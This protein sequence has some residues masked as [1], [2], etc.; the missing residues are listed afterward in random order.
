MLM[1]KSPVILMII[2][3]MSLLPVL[4]G[5]HTPAGRSAGEVID[6]STIATKVKAK[7]FDSGQLSGFAIN[8]DTF[9]QVVTMTGAVETQ[10][11]RELAEEIARS[12]RGVKDVNNLLELKK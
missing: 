3:L 1:K 4:S 5:C 7:L 10:R 2:L 11:Q 6:D 9:E 8:V 12:V